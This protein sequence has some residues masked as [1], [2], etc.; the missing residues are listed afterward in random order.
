MSAERIKIKIG[1]QEFGIKAQ[2]DDEESLQ[3]AAAEVERRVQEFQKAG[4]GSTQ[5]AVSMAAFHLAYELHEA[6][7]NPPQPDAKGESAVRDRLAHM[8]SRIDEAI[9]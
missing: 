3:Q 2:A 1:G 9:K 4:I 5:R 6:L 7:G 8:I